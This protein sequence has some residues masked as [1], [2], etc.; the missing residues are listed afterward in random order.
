MDNEL[1]DLAGIK[2][3]PDIFERADEL[4]VIAHD[5]FS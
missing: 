1:D 5:L 3:N 2:I 4:A